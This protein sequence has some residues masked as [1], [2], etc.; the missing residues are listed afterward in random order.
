MSMPT[1]PSKAKELLHYGFLGGDSVELC[2]LGGLLVR[3]SCLLGLGGSFRCGC[4]R[5]DVLDS[6]LYLAPYHPTAA[7]RRPLQTMASLA[8]GVRGVVELGRAEEDE[9]SAFERCKQGLEPSLT[10]Q[11]LKEG[12]NI[13]SIYTSEK[14]QPAASQPS[15]VVGNGSRP[16]ASETNCWIHS[17]HTWTLS[18]PA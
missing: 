10:S 2:V 12:V 16:F 7:E 13:I 4:H 5:V 6:L 9:Q 18:H 15:S 8:S 14:E 1:K 3:C 17:Q 11:R